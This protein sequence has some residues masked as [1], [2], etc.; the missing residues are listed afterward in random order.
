[1]LDTLLAEDRTWTAAQLVDALAAQQITLGP[2]HLRRYLRGMRAG[3]RRT[4]RTLDHKQ[5]PAKVA[6][7]R[8]EIAVLKGGRQSA[9]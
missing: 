7:A 2:R 3:Y 4:V 8:Q 6:T 9:T 1:M 5:D